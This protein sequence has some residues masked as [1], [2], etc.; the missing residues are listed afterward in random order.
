ML[1][2]SISYLFL[3]RTSLIF[4]YMLPLFWSSSSSS[5]C[6]YRSIARSWSLCAR[7]SSTVWRPLLSPLAG[8]LSMIRSTRRRLI[9]SWSSG[10]AWICYLNKQQLTLDCLYT[11]QKR[12]SQHIL[13][14]LL[15]TPRKSRRKSSVENWWVLE[16]TLDG[17]RW[18]VEFRNLR[19][20]SKALK[21]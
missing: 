17:R 12:E 16:E 18:Q 7:W 3:F 9:R 11:C 15:M 1:K 2:C 20:R 19:N 5:T 6:T 21:K 14:P 4:V 13:T 10:S 8:T